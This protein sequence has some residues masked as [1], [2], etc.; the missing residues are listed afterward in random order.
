[1]YSRLEKPLYANLIIKSENLCLPDF[2]GIGAMKS[3]TTWLFENLRCHPEVYLPEQKELYYFSLYF[4]TGR[5]SSYSSNFTNGVDLVKGAITPGYSTLSVDRIRFIRSIMP[6]VKLV[7][8]I[9]DPVERTWSEAY[10]NLV[11]KL[12][13]KLQ[14]VS[15][16]EFI[17][18]FQSDQCSQNGKAG[19][20]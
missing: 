17:K 11:A 4:Y 6:G 2:L 14:D 13:K 9:R 12:G 20:C 19:C 5:L 15:Y 8:I 10:M 18:Y 7:F 1:M 3:G 16:D